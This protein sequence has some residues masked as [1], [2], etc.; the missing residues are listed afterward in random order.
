[1]RQTYA[2]NVY[3]ASK[4]KLE[5]LPCPFSNILPHEDVASKRATEPAEQLA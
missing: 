1:M 3:S 2:G 5:V 4:V